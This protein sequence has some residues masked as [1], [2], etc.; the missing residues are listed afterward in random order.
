M[1]F[2]GGEN[3]YGMSPLVLQITYELLIRNKLAGVF[4]TCYCR[5]LNNGHIFFHTYTPLKR[6]LRQFGQVARM[7]SNRWAKQLIQ[8]TS[9]GW[10]LRP[11]GRP[12]KRS[13]DNIREILT[14][15]IQK[16]CEEMK[17]TAINHTV[18]RRN[19]NRKCLRLD[20]RQNM[21]KEALS[22]S[23]LSIPVCGLRIEP[24]KKRQPSS[25]REMSE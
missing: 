7:N 19:V 12:S 24:L 2:I 6:Q 22:Q 18:D 23:F 5:R 20:Q 25:L 8:T 13:F 15:R 10:A 17:N 11:R 1:S 21:V 16:K 4:Y 3:E 14:S 9:D